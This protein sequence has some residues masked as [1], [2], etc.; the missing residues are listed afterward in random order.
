MKNTLTPY[1]VGQYNV[2]AANSKEE[3]I[4]ILLDYHY[5]DSD[6]IEV[7]DVI[8]LTFNL[9]TMITDAEGNNMEI[10]G[11]WVSRIKKPEYMYGWE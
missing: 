2:V 8:D 10:L 9:R 7:K 4:Q 3:A 6:G 1:Q 11:D 5:V